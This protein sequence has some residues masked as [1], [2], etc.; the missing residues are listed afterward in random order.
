MK[1]I[2]FDFG[3]T[4]D[5]DGTHWSKK[6]R[7][8]YMR[9]GVTMGETDFA[10]AYVAAE[11]TMCD[12]RI[13]ASDGLRETLRMQVT[14]QCEKLQKQHPSIALVLGPDIAYQIADSCFDD[15]KENV[16]RVRPLLE[17][18]SRR[19]VLGL[20]SNFYGNLTAVCRELDLDSFFRV[21][22][23]STVVGVRKPHPG[24]FAV[25]LEQLHVVPLDTLV[26]GDSYDR[27]IVPAK[28][29][30]CMTVWL[31]GRIW[32]SPPDEMEADYVIHSLHQMNSHI[33]ERIAHE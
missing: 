17:Q 20:V 4:I 16:A 21:I 5:T 27:D 18:W 12:G 3:G 32:R 11:P 6:F 24:I 14:L 15:V 31:K 13:R 9:A 19:F 25:A 7:E 33:L 30:G 28:S 26:V 23:D 10:R 8:A 29:I 22:V 1:A 2:L